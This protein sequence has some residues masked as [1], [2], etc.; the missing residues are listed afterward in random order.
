MDITFAN[1]KLTI[2]I[3]VPTSAADVRKLP[4]SK[5]GKSRMIATTNGFAPVQGANG[6]KLALNVITGADVATK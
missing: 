2:V 1:G 3:P 5:S 4:L 6:V